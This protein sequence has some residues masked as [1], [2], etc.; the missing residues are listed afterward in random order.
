M[1]RIRRLWPTVT[2]LLGL[3]LAIYL[4][5]DAGAEDVAQAMLVVGWGMVPITYFTFFR[6][7]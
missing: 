3:V 6:S 1:S 7:S 4:I 2:A 5:I